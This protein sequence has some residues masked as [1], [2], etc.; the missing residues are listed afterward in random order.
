MDVFSN[1]RTIALDDVAHLSLFEG[2]DR[3]II[4]EFLCRN[5]FGDLLLIV[6]VDRRLWRPLSFFD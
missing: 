3:P 1:D 2:K 4:G 5:V 6:R